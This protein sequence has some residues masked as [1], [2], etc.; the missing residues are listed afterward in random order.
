VG[1]KDVVA[2]G[3]RIIAVMEVF[4]NKTNRLDQA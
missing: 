2:D 3:R 4:L 1:G